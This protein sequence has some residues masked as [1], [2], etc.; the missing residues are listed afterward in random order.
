MQSNGYES[1]QCNWY[2]G[3]RRRPGPAP[4]RG[5]A[6]HGLHQNAQRSDEGIIQEVRSPITVH[7]LVVPGFQQLRTLDLLT[8]DNV[9]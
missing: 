8:G 4:R 6:H 3:H 5:R 9:S 2:P 1:K 7:D